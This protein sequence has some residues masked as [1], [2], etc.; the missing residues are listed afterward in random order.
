MGLSI[1]RVRRELPGQLR[2]FLGNVPHGAGGFVVSA[3]S[4]AGLR[5]HRGRSGVMILAVMTR[6]TLPP[7][8][9]EIGAPSTVADDAFAGW[10]ILGPTIA[11]WR[12]LDLPTR[13]V[14]ALR[15]GTLAGENRGQDAL[16]DPCQALV[17][18]AQD[19][20]V[21]GTGPNP[22]RSRSP[23]RASPRSRSI[24]AIA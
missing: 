24:P 9:N 11:G 17:G 4:A 18:L 12:D 8:F 1:A 5:D 7:G 13:P 22:A 20:A 14:R 19:R 21:R 3:P 23:A 15:N 16:G 2:S 6:G 10:V